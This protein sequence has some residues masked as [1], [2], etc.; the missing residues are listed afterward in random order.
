MVYA[1]Y[2]KGSWEFGLKDQGTTNG[3]KVFLQT[4]E[5]INCTEKEAQYPL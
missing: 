1:F 2:E 5:D 4:D 3:K